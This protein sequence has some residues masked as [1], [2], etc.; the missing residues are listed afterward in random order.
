MPEFEINRRELSLHST[1]HRYKNDLAQV[2]SQEEKV[3][4]S[5]ASASGD[6]SRS[7]ILSTENA[8]YRSEESSPLIQDKNKQPNESSGGNQTV[9]SVYQ[10]MFKDLARMESPYERK[11]FKEFITKDFSDRFVS[12]HKKLPK[13]YRSYLLN[14]S[15][16]KSPIPPGLQAI[17]ERSKKSVEDIASILG[18]VAQQSPEEAQAL[19]SQLDK[20]LQTQVM[21]VQSQSFTSAQKL[22]LL[23]GVHKSMLENFIS[24]PRAVV[25][26]LSLLSL[27]GIFVA[28]AVLGGPVGG[29]FAVGLAEMGAISVHFMASRAARVFASVFEYVRLSRQLSTVDK[30]IS[31]KKAAISSNKD[32]DHQVKLEGELLKLQAK[33]STLEDKY[34]ANNQQLLLKSMEFFY[35]CGHVGCCCYDSSAGNCRTYGGCTI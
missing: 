26:A 28:G 10:S 9:S 30:E 34:A 18:Q 6:V 23:E 13:I 7:P 2:R 1:I 21:S 24:V 15:Q 8:R 35:G 31:E 33:R 12:V 25:S 27:G 5:D 29:I 4:K 11:I 3:Q 32:P 14:Q 17:H 22:A 19:F 16:D 20:T